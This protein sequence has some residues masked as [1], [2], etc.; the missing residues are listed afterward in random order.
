ME[1]RAPGTVQ[2]GLPVEASSGVASSKLPWFT[3]GALL[4][5]DKRQPGLALNRLKHLKNIFLHDFLKQKPWS[6]KTQR[7]TI[8]LDEDSPA[9]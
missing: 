3:L 4:V 9:K 6:V 1:M 8:I 7:E 2:E 5:K